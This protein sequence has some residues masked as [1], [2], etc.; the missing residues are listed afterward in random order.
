M[1]DLE[2]PV[3]TKLRQADAARKLT[4]V[5]RKPG[6][7]QPLHVAPEL[8]EH[9][10]TDHP[11]DAA[12]EGGDPDWMSH[13]AFSIGKGGVRKFR[14]TISNARLALQTAPQWHRGFAY[15]EF[16]KDVFITRY[17]GSKELA[18]G[19]RVEDDQILTLR[20][21]LTGATGED[22]GSGLVRDGLRL[23]ALG[24]RFH[25]VRD[26]LDG[27]KWDG[28]ARVDRWLTTYLGAEASEYT[29]AVGQAWLISAVARVRE[30]GCTADGTLVL[31]GKQKIGK[32]DAM[33]ALCPD[34]RW[35]G[36]IGGGSLASKDTKLLLRG[37]WFVELSEMSAAHKSAPDE[38]KAFLTRKVDHYRGPWDRKDQMQP[39]QCVFW[40]TT[41]SQTYLKD[42]TGNRR[43]WPVRCSPVVV[44][45]AG[46]FLDRV[47]LTQD[48]DQIWAEADELYRT[49]V[50]W[51]LDARAEALAAGAQA[52]RMLDDPWE[53]VIAEFLVGKSVIMVNEILAALG[54]PIDRATSADGRR[55][56]ALLRKLG[57]DKRR[58]EVGGVRV[59]LWEKEDSGGR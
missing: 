2:L 14:K 24:E 26:Y 27:V 28:V 5:A 19:Q 52:E 39:R 21:A 3:K 11:L 50:G 53:L 20:D 41:N 44:S 25:P 42:E 8:A 37:K 51:S 43:F 15:N 30:P 45:A 55:I 38:L 10:Y 35:M 16:N 54:K 22:F 1:A 33:H 40:G 32:N 31:E 17:L 59:V 9:G 29:S 13:L 12:P 57:W 58:A 34:A 4:L 6:D 48:R 49:G 56:G 7:P 23:A 36:E 18:E 46:S 47:G